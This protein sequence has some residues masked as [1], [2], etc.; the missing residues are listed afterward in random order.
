M[1]ASAVPGGELPH[2]T[3]GASPLCHEALQRP[4]EL[5]GRRRRSRRVEEAPL[6]FF[7]WF[8]VT[9]D[10]LSCGRMESSWIHLTPPATK[11]SHLLVLVLHLLPILLYCSTSFFSSSTFT[12]FILLSYSSTSSSISSFFSPRPPPLPSSSTSSPSSLLPPPPFLSPPLS[13]APSPPLSLPSPPPHSPPVLHFHL[14]L[15]HPLF[16]LHLLLQ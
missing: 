12:S 2:Q 8:V 9:V 15:P 11:G 7:H 6:V 16:L 1:S 14:L 4:G 5:T 3:T 10:V 13:L